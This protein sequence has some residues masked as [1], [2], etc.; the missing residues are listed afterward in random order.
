MTESFKK[1]HGSMCK[2]PNE[3]SGIEYVLLK[4][5]AICYFRLTRYAEFGTI[6][7]RVSVIIRRVERS[8]G[9]PVAGRTAMENR[10]MRQYPEEIL[11]YGAAMGECGGH[12]LFCF[13]MTQ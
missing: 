13:K 4:M 3:W 10:I 11:R 8:A 6:L 2:H 7:Y 12:V 1:K 5:T 9:L